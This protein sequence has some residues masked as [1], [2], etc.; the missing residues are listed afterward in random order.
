V[1]REAFA[2][3]DRWMFTAEP[4]HL[5]HARSLADAKSK[6]A[7]LVGPAKLA[8]ARADLWV[9]SH[10]QASI[11]LFGATSADA[12]P[13]LILGT[14]WVTALPHDVDDLISILQSSLELPALAGIK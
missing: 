7:E 9:A 12:V 8:A 10:L 2:E 6:A 4:G 11:R 1:K 3:F 5:W 14:H 13:K